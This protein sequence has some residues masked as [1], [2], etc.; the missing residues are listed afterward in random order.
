MFSEPRGSD[1][2]MRQSVA[3]GPLVSV[4]G[5]AGA[6]A[7]GDAHLRIAVDPDTG[8]VHLAASAGLGLFAYGRASSP[9]PK[10]ADLGTFLANTVNS[11]PAQSTKGNRLPDLGV[12]VKLDLLYGCNTFDPGALPDQEITADPETRCVQCV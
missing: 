6:R 5:R 11:L 4:N 3:E 10:G 2:L 7:P 9:A 1:V 8:A 12:P